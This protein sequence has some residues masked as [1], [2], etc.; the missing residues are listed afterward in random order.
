MSIETDTRDRVI[1]LEAEVESL[2][3]KVTSMDAKV[4]A[5]HELL[6]QA[7]GARWFLIAAAGLGG[8][9]SAKLTMFLPWL[10][11]K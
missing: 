4:T 2:S 5:M 9:I 7:K 3:E 8:F 6:L 10:G 1:R 11:G